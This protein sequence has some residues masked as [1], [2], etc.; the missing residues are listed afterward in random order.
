MTKY[1]SEQFQSVSKPINFIRLVALS[2]WEFCWFI[3]NKI[4]CCNRSNGVASRCP[5]VQFVGSDVSGE[6]WSLPGTRAVTWSYTHC[7][8][9]RRTHRITCPAFHAQLLI[10]FTR[11]VLTWPGG[12]DL[13]NWRFQAPG[14][15][16]A[17]GCEV[18]TVYMDALAQGM[19]LFMY[20]QC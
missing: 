14:L 12:L 20:I 11:P 15:A 19:I 17:N 6:R 8:Q 16:R 4:F 3:S 1:W 13:S 2:S 18:L 9:H 7:C 5:E 10:N